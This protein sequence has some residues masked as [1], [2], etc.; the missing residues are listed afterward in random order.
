LLRRIL[1]DVVANVFPGRASASILFLLRISITP[2]SKAP[3]VIGRKNPPISYN[4]PPRAGATKF[5][6]LRVPN[7]IPMAFVL[8][9]GV[10]EVSVQAEAADSE[11]TDTHPMQKYKAHIVGY[12]IRTGVIAKTT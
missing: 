5:A 4:V 1:V 11:S 10:T 7:K 2:K 8:L 3:P 9:S 12:S 6:A